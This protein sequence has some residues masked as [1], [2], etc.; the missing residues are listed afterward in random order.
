MQ[1]RLS[2]RKCI[3]INFFSPQQLTTRESRVSHSQAR[4]LLFHRVIS[5][6]KIWFQDSVFEEA[7]AHWMGRATPVRKTSNRA[8]PD[9]PI[10]RP[11]LQRISSVVIGQ[12]S[13]LH[14]LG[15]C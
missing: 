14:E 2:S 6:S 8:K 12:A 1:T 13:R 15:A 11:Q 4:S 3:W 7:F 9:I 10:A 5:G